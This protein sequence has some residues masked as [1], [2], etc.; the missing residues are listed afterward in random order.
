MLIYFL[1]WATLVGSGLKKE[2]AYFT[3]I[4]LEHCAI[5]LLLWVSKS[6]PHLS[7]PTCDQKIETMKFGV[8]KERELAA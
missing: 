3:K 6:R 1:T 8:S 5:A 7:L 2:S 4:I